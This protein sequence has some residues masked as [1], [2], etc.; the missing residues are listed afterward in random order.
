MTTSFFITSLLQKNSLTVAAVEERYREP[1]S[2]GCAGNRAFVSQAMSAAKRSFS[3]AL[4]ERLP[5]NEFGIDR[6]VYNSNYM[7]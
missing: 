2:Q 4:H 3:F 7:V 5:L 6:L 1:L